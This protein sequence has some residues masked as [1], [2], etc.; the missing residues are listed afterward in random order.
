[1]PAQR[2]LVDMVDDSLDEEADENSL[3]HG[4]RLLGSREILEQITA[5]V[6]AGSSHPRLA[7]DFLD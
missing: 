7:E 4:Y 5:K 3:R 1:M 2:E 6:K